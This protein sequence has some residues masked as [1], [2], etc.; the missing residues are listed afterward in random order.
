MN[1]KVAIPVIVG[2]LVLAAVI[3]FTMRSGNANLVADLKGK[4]VWLKCNNPNCGAVYQIPAIDYAVAI[5]KKQTDDV[6]VILGLKCQKCGEDSAFR[7][8][9]CEKCGNVFPFSAGAFGDFADRCPSCG[10][11][12]TEQMRQSGQ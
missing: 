10:F 6:S 3:T 1:K 12:K 11:S 8:E 9:K 4:T 5:E 7:V 2:C